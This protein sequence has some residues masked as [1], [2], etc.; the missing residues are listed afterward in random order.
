[1]PT[2][3]DILTQAY[4]AFNA[5]ELERA[6]AAMHP[7]VD[8]PNGMEGGYVHGHDGVRDYWTRQWR[9]IDPHVEPRCFSTNDAGHIVVDVRQV[10][11]DRS[12]RIVTDQMVQHVYVLEGGLIKH[13]AIRK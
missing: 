5:R 2:E 8:W 9:V 1:M 12:G 11:R 7:D 4:E 6:L 3:R 10:V 13:M